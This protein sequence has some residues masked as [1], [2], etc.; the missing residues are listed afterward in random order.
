MT[1]W[2]LAQWRLVG[3][4]PTFRGPEDGDVSPKHSHLLTSLHKPKSRKY[5]PSL[6]QNLTKHV[7]SA[8]RFF[9]AVCIQN[10]KDRLYFPYMS[11]N[12]LQSCLTRSQVITRWHPEICHDRNYAVVPWLITSCTQNSISRVQCLEKLLQKALTQPYTRNR[13][14]SPPAKVRT[15]E[16]AK[17][18]FTWTT[19]DPRRP[20]PPTIS[21]E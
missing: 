10:T 6:K 17:Q 1:F 7:L 9:H 19:K 11:S 21:Q 2:V 8:T 5:L 15:T 18:V 14:P 13:I 3:K 16:P 20:H 4:M 12:W